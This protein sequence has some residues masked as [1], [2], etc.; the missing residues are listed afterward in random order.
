V[1]D[2]ERRRS[3][4]M[5]RRR[6][7]DDVDVDRADPKRL[8]LLQRLEPERPWWVKISWDDTKYGAPTRSARRRPPEMWSA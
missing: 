4:R 1:V 6:D 8:V 3:R 5:A 2:E 7:D